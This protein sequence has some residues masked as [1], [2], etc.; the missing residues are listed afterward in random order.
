MRTLNEKII[1]INKSSR[2]ESKQQFSRIF[3]KER[4]DF[5]QAIFAWC[6][7]NA[8]RAIDRDTLEEAIQWDHFAARV[9]CLDCDPL[10]SPELESH[11][12]K[13]ATR[14]PLPNV[15]FSPRIAQ[16][17]RWLHVLSIALATGGHTAMVKRWMMLDQGNNQ[18]NVV[19]LAQ[20]GPVPDSLISSVESTGGNV[21]RL[22]PE[23]GLLIRAAQLREKAWAEAD[24][25]VLHVHPSDVIPMVAFGVSGGPPVMLVNHASHI[26]WVGGSVADIT[27]NAWDP[28]F[29]RE[30][31]VR[32][33]GIERSDFLPIPVLEPNLSDTHYELRAT[34]RKLL[35]LPSEAVVLLTVGENYKYTPL[36]G[37]DFLQAAAAILQENP[38]VY[39]IAVGK[40]EDGRWKT[41]REAMGGRLLALGRQLDVTPYHEVADLYLEGFPLGS[42]TALLEA[43]IRGIPCVL[44]PKVCPPFF[45]SAMTGLK[46]L[47]Q[48][49]D[50]D[51]YI[52][53][54]I[55]LIEN[56]Q[57][58]ERLGPLLAIEIKKKNTGDA[59]VQHL[60]KVQS[61]LPPTH[62]LHPLPNP[63]PL[64]KHF[65][66]FW[67]AFSSVVYK[68]VL[69]YEFINFISL[70]PKIDEVLWKSIRTVKIGLAHDA[71]SNLLMNI[72]D[73]CYWLN[74]FSLT[75]HFYEYA[76]KLHPL[77]LQKLTKYFL[78][79]MGRPGMKLRD[80]L[81]KLKHHFR[82]MKSNHW[83]IR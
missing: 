66:T 16:P 37:L 35:N 56:K 57:E 2:F 34:N 80:S 32:Y 6:L 55:R 1:G 11:L 54:A 20:K 45:T 61:H 77:S 78:L 69:T 75:Q 47:I 51:A 64:P 79:R 59:W 68:D 58:R 76:V 36:P 31:T 5:N 46:N 83:A 41:V 50:V 48:P 7:R 10:S 27:L 23:A 44:A 43:G 24:F 53:Q 74:D 9:A 29:V 3:A 65:V 14:Y 28:E 81:S 82:T 26:F 60:R 12:L 71:L 42:T 40:E 33:R 22:D 8:K 15:K 17:Q 62:Q 73:H 38:N 49:A 67:S 13:A 30:W 52:K 63:I 18:H 25:V 70:R 19:L 72:G 21:T 4:L 39:L